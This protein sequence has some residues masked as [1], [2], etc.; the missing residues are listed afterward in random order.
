MERYTP[1][2]GMIVCSEGGD[3]VLYEDHIACFKSFEEHHRA[4]VSQLEGEV[5]KLQRRLADIESFFSRYSE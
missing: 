2:R 4:T 1:V 3:Y 5:E